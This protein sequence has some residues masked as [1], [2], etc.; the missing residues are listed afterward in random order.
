MATLKGSFDVATACQTKTLLHLSQM[1]WYPGKSVS[2]FESFVNF[3]GKV[4]ALVGKSVMMCCPSLTLCSINVDTIGAVARDQII[5]FNDLEEAERSIRQ[6]L[7][8]TQ[9]HLEQL[10]NEVQKSGHSGENYVHESP[11]KVLQDVAKQI[12]RLEPDREESKSI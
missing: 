6:D 3:R 10:Y 12:L 5:A 9:L 4:Q 7:Y 11:L 8:W 2:N 1:S